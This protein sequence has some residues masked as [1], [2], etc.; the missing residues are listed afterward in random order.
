MGKWIEMSNNSTKGFEKGEQ[1]L[2]GDDDL[3]AHVNGSSKDKNNWKRFWISNSDKHWPEKCQIHRCSGVAEVG[4]H[5][6]IK[7]M[8]G[9]KWYFILPTCQKCNMD[10]SSFYRESDAWC[11]AKS[12]AV[13]I[14]TP[15][16]DCCFE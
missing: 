5:V 7:G 2:L 15:F 16:K 10:T 13:A 6:Y 14:A 9:N 3:V 4:A 11:S 1:I 8:T 12:R